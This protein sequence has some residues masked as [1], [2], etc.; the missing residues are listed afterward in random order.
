MSR[1]YKSVQVLSSLQILSHQN[2]TLFLLKSEAF[3]ELRQ[4]RIILR[5]PHS[6]QRTVLLTTIA[7][8]VACVF[9]DQQDCRELS[10]PLLLSAEKL[11]QKNSTL[12]HLLVIFI[13]KSFLEDTYKF[14]VKP[15][16]AFL[17]PHVKPFPDFIT[18]LLI[19]TV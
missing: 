10:F 7:C 19:I 11:A 14:P 2:H 16:L 8:T 1:L 17:V 4:K 13:L 12:F 15:G 3:T 9:S 18:D 5:P 6:C